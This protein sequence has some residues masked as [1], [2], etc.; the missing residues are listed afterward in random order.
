MKIDL[1]VLISIKPKMTVDQKNTIKYSDSILSVE[2]AID[3]NRCLIREGSGSDDDTKVKYTPKVMLSEKAV[4]NSIQKLISKK[5]EN[6]YEL[7]H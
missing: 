3:E 6:G 7:V 5:Q 2:Y 1:T 4:V